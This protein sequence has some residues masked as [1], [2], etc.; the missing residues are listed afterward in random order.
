VGDGAAYVYEQT[1]S[2]DVLLIDGYDAKRIVDALASEEFYA[3]C[4]KALAPG[5]LAIFNLWGSDRHFDLYFE[6]VARVFDDHT[7][8]LPAE[9]KGNIQLLAFKSPL[10]VADFADLAARASDLQK[11][12]GL[13]M[14]AFLD[15]MKQYNTVTEAA[16]LL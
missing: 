1:G 12:L 5:G 9:K 16:F 15:R 10:P 3:A 6:R 7:L 8:I 4:L 2:L 14:P 13:E 11:V